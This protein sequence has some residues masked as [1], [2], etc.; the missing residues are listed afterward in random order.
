MLKADGHY[1]LLKSIA[2]SRGASIEQLSAYAKC[3]TAS[4]AKKL[5]KKQRFW[6]DEAVNIRRGLRVTE[7]SIEELF[8]LNEDK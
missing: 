5:A 8:E 6:L 3:T 2:N 4:M 1:Q 7:F